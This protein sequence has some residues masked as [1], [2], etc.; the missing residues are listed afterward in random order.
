MSQLLPN[1]SL[2]EELQ[3]SEE[4]F[5]S[6]FYQA[7]VGMV[8]VRMSDARF[9]RA[10]N[11]I[12]DLLGYTE[13]EFC[14]KTIPE[15]THPDDVMTDMENTIKM[16]NGE[17]NMFSIEKRLLK[18][19]SNPV[20]IRLTAVSVARDA[21]GQATYGMAVCEDISQIKL[22]EQALHESEERFKAMAD[23][24]PVAIHVT[25]TEPKTIYVNKGWLDYTGLDYEESMGLQWQSAIHPDD[26]KSYIEAFLDAFTQR[27]P[28]RFETRIRKANGDFG[29]MLT[30]GVPRYT[31]DGQFLG[32]IGTG[33]DITDRKQAEAF[34]EQAKLQAEEAN[35]K[36]SEFLS[37]MSHELRTPL[38]SIIGFSEMLAEGFAGDLDPKQ[39]EFAG[40]VSASGHHLL[41]LIND[42]LDIAKIEA[43]KMKLRLEWVEIFPL[44]EDIQIMMNKLA[45][46]KEVTLSFLVQPNLETIQLDP[47]RFKQVLINLISNAIKFNVPGGSIFVR[48]FKSQDEQWLMGEVQDTGIGISKDKLPELFQKFYQVDTTETRSHEGTG[49]GLALTRD[50]IELHGGS[51]RV[52]S[53]EGIGSIFTFKLPVS[54][55]TNHMLD[56]SNGERE[57][58]SERHYSY[59]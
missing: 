1:K 3:R 9:V 42:L 54:N 25:D 28:F 46:Q 13:V 56:M 45:S 50:L 16:I 24:A 20:W 34:L 35:R 32:Y 38:N 58:E 7:A 47:G 52:S 23:A 4:L 22:T 43:G 19:D 10:N 39:K 53:K 55:R 15:I 14:E 6:T 44:I 57:S 48:L 36:K 17:I 11:R 40:Y 33:I 21:Q 26:V 37:L 41:N 59:R 51:I 8:H 12:C 2:F 49:L 5:S 30:T 27:E 18:K 29:W 31:S